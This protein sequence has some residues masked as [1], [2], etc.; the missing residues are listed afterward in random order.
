MEQLERERGEHQSRVE[1]LV[2]DNR[3]KDDRNKDFERRIENL[4]KEQA[5]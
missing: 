3:F 1:E 5:L 2:R 4:A